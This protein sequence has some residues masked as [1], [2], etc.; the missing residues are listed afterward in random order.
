M[1]VRTNH[2]VAQ[3]HDDLFQLFSTSIDGGQTWTL[4]FENESVVTPICMVSLVQEGGLLYFS[5]P[6]DFHSRAKMTIAVSTDQGQDFSEQYLIY[7]GPSGYS[8]LAV[9]S[10]GDI[11]LLFENGAV[12]YDERLTLVKF[13][14]NE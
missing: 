14:R 10:N 7:A 8:D 2:P 5:F 6:N 13:L 12:E 1:A 3:P 4:A 11:L 9:L